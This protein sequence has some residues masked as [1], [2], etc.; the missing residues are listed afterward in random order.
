MGAGNKKER[1]SMEKLL[2]TQEVSEILGHTKDP[3]YRFVR[4]LRKKGIL[5]GAK[6]GNKLM[7][8]ESDVENYINNQFES[9]NKRVYHIE[10]K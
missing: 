9:Q 6:I 10:R 8:R 3:K 7:F 5:E 4:E 1:G 2:T